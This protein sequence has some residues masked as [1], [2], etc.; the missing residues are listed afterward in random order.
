MSQPSP[1]ART[2]GFGC[3]D[4]V[5]PHHVE[6]T[7]P[8]GRTGEVVVVE[9]YGIRAGIDGNPELEER[10]RLARS[11]WSAIAEPLKRSFNERL[12][13]KRLAAGRWQVGANKVERLLG[14][15]L[16]V[17]AWAVEAAEPTMIP[18]AVRN[19][20]GLRPEERWWLYTMAAAATGRADD[21]EIGWRK[22]IRIALT[23][24]PTDE[25]EQRAVRA[26]RR[27][28]TEVPSLFDLPESDPARTSR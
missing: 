6:V 28:T 20:Q 22:A 9:R 7:I 2:V 26:K 25:A 27:V 14:K 3:P 8:A 18:N 16:L 19:W 24:N 5:E 1:P 13:E 23:E 15:E 4:G 17:L 21:T 12:R 10:C 11:A